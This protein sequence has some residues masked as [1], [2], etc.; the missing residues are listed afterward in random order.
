MA[1]SPSSRPTHP[2]SSPMELPFVNKDDIFQYYN[3]NTPS[4]EMIFKRTPS[5]VGRN[6]ELCHP[7]RS[8]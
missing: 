1:I 4:D 5:Q 3:D 7:P 2:Q 6:V 8:T